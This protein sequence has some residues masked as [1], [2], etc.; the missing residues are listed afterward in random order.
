M[1]LIK[2]PMPPRPP[3]TSTLGPKTRS[4]HGLITSLRATLRTFALTTFAFLKR[5]LRYFEEHAGGITAIFTVVLS[6]ST[7]LLWLTTEQMREETKSSIDA[8]NRLAG[9]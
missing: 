7:V 2:L 6:V 1:R 9:A 4:L 3:K 8:S 5:L